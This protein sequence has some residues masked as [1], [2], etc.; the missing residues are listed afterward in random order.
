PPPDSP[1]SP[2][3][4]PPSGPPPEPFPLAPSAHVPDVEELAQAAAGPASQ[5]PAPSV[6]APSVRAPSVPA[7]SVR[8]PAAA[9]RAVSAPPAAPANVDGVSLE[10]VSG[11][12]DLPEDSQSEL[13]RNAELVTLAPGEEARTFAVA[14]VTAGA[15][16]IMPAIADAS[17]AR[18][19]RGE[20]VFTHGTVGEGVALRVVG[21]EPGTRV[22]IWSAEQLAA[23]T[24][25]C[26]WVAD[27]LSQV[28]DR[29][30]A[31]AG[32][33]MGPLG[34]SLDDMFRPMV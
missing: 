5:A 20:V 33:V 25:A 22:A 9:A 4:Y 3:A 23:A 32:A 31:L 13:S 1:L 10:N 21:A 17:C 30:Q 15:V 28:A 12:A 19:R 29:F 2:S 6:R 26:P 34:D 18:A 27:E 7:P 16:D 24:S 8:A 11:L 14:L